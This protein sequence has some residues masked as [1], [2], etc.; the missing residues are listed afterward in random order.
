MTCCNLSRLTFVVQLM[1]YIASFI[2]VLTMVLWKFGT[3]NAVKKWCSDTK[4]LR[5]SSTLNVY[6]FQPWS[7]AH[8]TTVANSWPLIDSR[9]SPLS[10]ISQADECQSNL[11]HAWRQS[12]IRPSGEEQ[13]NLLASL[14]SFPVRARF[15]FDPIH[16]GKYILKFEYSKR[17]P[18]IT[19]ET[20]EANPQ[21]ISV[22]TH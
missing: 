5:A 9:L 20:I 2:R 3:F 8:L 12:S 19:T 1:K 15:G 18:N 6:F 16:A 22:F 10:H 13:L 14:S 7:N 11:L 17:I 4:S 21:S